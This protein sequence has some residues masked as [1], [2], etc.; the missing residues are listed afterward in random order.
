MRAL[1]EAIDEIN[2]ALSEGN[3]NDVR[4]L[5]S[6][7]FPAFDSKVIVKIVFELAES[8]YAKNHIERAERCYRLAIRL[9]EC[10]FPAEIQAR[11]AKRRLAEVLQ[12]QDRTEEAQLLL[13]SLE[14]PTNRLGGCDTN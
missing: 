7:V 12:N 3:C 2:H 6:D 10:C 13:A 14:L 11:F 9:H 5:L 1:S 8:T 4:S